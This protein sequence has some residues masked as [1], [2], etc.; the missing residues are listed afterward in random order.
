MDKLKELN[1]YQNTNIVIVSDHGMAAL[2]R[3]NII[4][5]REYVNITLID[6]SRSIYGIVSHIRT[7][8]GAVG[9]C[10]TIN[11]SF[12]KLFYFKLIIRKKKFINHF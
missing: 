10:E 12:I 4:N 7:I 3:A 8:V 2:K 5:I 6:K 9:F 11:Y 1:L